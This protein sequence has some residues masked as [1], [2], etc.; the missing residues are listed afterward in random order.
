MQCLVFVWNPF[1]LIPLAVVGV[2]E[3]LWLVMNSYGILLCI[4]K[5]L[6][7][8]VFNAAFQ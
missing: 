2:V 7:P 4:L 1:I 5:Y 6:K 8:L 3:V